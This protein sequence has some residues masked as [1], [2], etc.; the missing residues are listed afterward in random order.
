MQLAMVGLGRMGGRVQRL[1]QGGHQVVVFDRS[2]EAVQAHVG[3]GANGAKDPA[4]P[5]W[6]RCVGLSGSGHYVE[7]IYNG[8]E[9]G[10]L[11]NYAEGYEILHQPKDFDLDLHQSAAVWNRGSLVR[12]WLNELIERAVAKDTEHAVKTA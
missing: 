6:L 11:Q 1:L 10:M 8:I 9:Y 2:A 7:M 5:D 12:S 4:P 3:M